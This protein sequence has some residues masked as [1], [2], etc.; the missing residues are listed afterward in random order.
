MSSIGRA[1]LS[2]RA[3]TR[4]CVGCG[5]VIKAESRYCPHCGAY[6]NPFQDRMRRIR[7]WREKW[8]AVRSVFLFYSAILATTVPLYWIP[9]DKEALGMIIVS[10]VDVLII[11]GY[12]YISRVELGK[13][14]RVGSQTAKTVFTGVFLTCSLI[15]LNLAYHLLLLPALLDLKIPSIIETFL[16][17]GYGLGIIL[18]F[19]CV[20]PALWEEIAFRGLIQSKLAIAI[21]KK[22]AW[23]LT[24]VMFTIIHVAVLSWGVLLLLGLFLGW[25]R[26]RTGSL[27]PGM[28]IHFLYNFVVVILEFCFGL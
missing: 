21:G 11:V 17:G 27:I 19:I 4:V 1:S 2:T 24:A 16:K 9:D 8:R 15:L 14:F 12:G 22:E 23:L 25:L 7:N 13:L 3:T 5:E 26:N 10:L 6:L 20:M 28:I 18:L